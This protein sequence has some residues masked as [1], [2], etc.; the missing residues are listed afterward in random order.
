MPTE[1]DEWKEKLT[2]EQYH[3]LREKGTERPFSGKYDQEFKPGMYMCGA[4]GA[5]L[6]VS[7]TKFDAGC[8][9]PSFDA[10]KAGAVKEQDDASLGL[11]RREVVCNKCGSHLGHV[12]DDGPTAT[13][14]RYCINSLAL[15]FK[16]KEGPEAEQK[17][18]Q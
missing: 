10:A 17:N 14:Q 7:E 11:V 15:N 5:D 8:G 18:R 16:P 3:V 4:C 13:G 9:W 12:F 1:N 6:F 2:P